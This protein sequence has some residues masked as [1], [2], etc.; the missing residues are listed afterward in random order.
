[1]SKVVNEFV[2]KFYV[3]LVFVGG[4]IISMKTG[5]LYLIFGAFA[6][7]LQKISLKVIQIDCIC[8]TGD[9]TTI[10]LQQMGFVIDYPEL[11]KSIDISHIIAIGFI[12][13]RV[14]GIV[15]RVF[16]DAAA[17]DAAAA[18]AA[19]AA[20][21]AQKCSSSITCSRTCDSRE[22]VHRLREQICENM[23]FESVDLFFQKFHWDIV[24]VGGDSTEILVYLFAKERLSYVDI[25]YSAGEL[26]KLQNL[27]IFSLLFLSQLSIEGFKKFYSNKVDCSKI[28][29]S[30]GFINLPVVSIT[31]LLNFLIIRVIVF[32]ILWLLGLAVGYYTTVLKHPENVN[33]FFIYIFVVKKLFKF[34]LILYLRLFLVKIR[35]Y[36]WKRL[37]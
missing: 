9:T 12:V 8:R 28:M 30:A 29:F 32:R 34:F 18:A 22:E 10:K 16:K 6:G 25:I 15:F 27:G 14:R 17:A 37:L 31:I 11:V 2:Y 5:A 35:I 21:K 36:C 19:A 33:K 7:L 13:I 3:L 4:N 1:M 24:P 23:G 20:E 26:V